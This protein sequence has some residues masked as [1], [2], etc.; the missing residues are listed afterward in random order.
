[1]TDER[2][3]VRVLH[4]AR[5]WRGNTGYP[6]ADRTPLTQA[7]VDRVDESD[8]GL[9]DLPVAAFRRRDPMPAALAPLPVERDR[10]DLGAPEV[11]PDP[12]HAHRTT[13]APGDA[14]RNAARR[15]GA[16]WPCLASCSTPTPSTRSV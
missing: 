4:Q 3:R 7:R 1:M 16:A 14:A 5:R 9:D 13:R 12:H 11:Y 10:L 8:Q 15:A 6:D 2:R